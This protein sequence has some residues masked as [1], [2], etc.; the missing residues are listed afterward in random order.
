M[1]INELVKR[2]R[3]GDNE[4]FGQIYDCYAQ[5]IFRY[6]RLKIQ[7]R[8][9]AEDALQ[10]V[11]IKAFRGLNGLNMEKLNFP[12]WLYKIAS[13]T[14]NDFF[15]KKYRAPEITPIDENFD[16]PS[17]VSLEKDFSVNWDWN[18][19]RAS[20]SQ[21]PEIYKQVLELRFI[22]GFSLTETADI[23]KKSNLS[24]RLIQ[25]RALKK[26]KIILEQDDFNN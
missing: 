19:A 16:P 12:A 7:N 5:K 14:V 6:I 23:L 1:E 13:N 25:Y 11:F 21:L 3:E 8:E 2:A 24:I 18:L 17:R 22:Q 26:V 20:F 9:E 15:R 10:E 4:A